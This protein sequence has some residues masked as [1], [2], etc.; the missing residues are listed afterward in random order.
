M[1]KIFQLFPEKNNRD[2]N[3]KP[4]EEKPENDQNQYQENKMDY[5]LEKMHQISCTTLNSEDYSRLAYLKEYLRGIAGDYSQDAYN[6]RLNEL[7]KQ[8]LLDILP[9]L[10]L[11][12]EEFKSRPAYGHA[13]VKA[14]EEKDMENYRE[15]SKKDGD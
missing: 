10:N 12:L 13:L 4:K 15:K 8:D 2:N 11:G 7:R 1:A 6:D 3:E 5:F 9:L 14:I